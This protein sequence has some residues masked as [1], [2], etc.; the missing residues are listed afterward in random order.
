MRGILLII[1]SCLLHFVFIESKICPK[2]QLPSFLATKHPM[3]VVPKEPLN[4]TRCLYPQDIIIHSLLENLTK[5]NTPVCVYIVPLRDDY[6]K[7]YFP[8]EH[9]AYFKTFWKENGE[10]CLKYYDSE[11]LGFYNFDKYGNLP[12]D[13]LY[14]CSRGFD[15]ATDDNR[16]DQLNVYLSQLMLSYIQEMEGK[17]SHRLMRCYDRDTDLVNSHWTLYNCMFAVMNRTFSVG[18]LSFNSFFV[19]QMDE[20]V[21]FSHLKNTFLS[22]QASQEGCA[23]ADV[24]AT[25]RIQILN[26][27]TPNNFLDDG[28]CTGT[29]NLYGFD[30]L[31]CCYLNALNCLYTASPYSTEYDPTTQNLEGKVLRD[32]QFL[33]IKGSLNSSTPELKFRGPRKDILT[34]L[35]PQCYT[36]LNI[37]YDKDFVFK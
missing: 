11:V 25:G 7:F 35:A 15:N 32:D 4:K 31:C 21:D 24:D 8:T 1:V 5:I 36:L 23:I 17:P 22:A 19:D 20:S 10:R 37:T 34:D 27:I 12:T 13:I 33:C 28:E 29:L 9:D 30:L 2:C 16:E 6:L 26:S 18:P 3:H 14:S